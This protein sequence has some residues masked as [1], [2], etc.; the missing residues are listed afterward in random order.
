MLVLCTTYC[1]WMWGK[2]V[3][4]RILLIY[5][6]SKEVNYVSNWAPVL[7]STYCPVVLIISR[8]NYK[9]RGFVMHFHLGFPFGLPELTSQPQHHVSG[10][11]WTQRLFLEGRNKYIAEGMGNFKYRVRERKNPTAPSALC[12]DCTCIYTK[13][14]KLTYFAKKTKNYCTYKGFMFKKVIF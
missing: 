4:V 10:L 2:V 3:E 8:Q 5:I 12:K 1:L 11:V 14:I 7:A 6:I 13:D 9:T